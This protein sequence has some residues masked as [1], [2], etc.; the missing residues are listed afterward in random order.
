MWFDVIEKDEKHDVAL[1]KILYFSAMKEPVGKEAHGRPPDTFSPFVSLPIS[2]EKPVP[3]QEVAILGF[4]LGSW[5]TPVIQGGNIGATNATLDWVQDFPA[6]RHDL[7]V[8]SI[9]GNH[10]DSGCPLVDAHTGQVLGIITQ[11]VP[12]PLA[13]N[14]VQQ[15][16]LMV[17]IPAKW[18]TDILARNH[19]ADAPS[20]DLKTW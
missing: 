15:S 16:G 6:G 13:Q 20:S 2:R 18:I 8:I 12:A 5:V 11:Y 9:S 10:G 7:L 1:C 19:I 14:V 17:A 3:G 4:P